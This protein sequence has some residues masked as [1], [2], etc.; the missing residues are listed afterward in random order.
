MGPEQIKL[1][2]DKEK[3]GLCLALSEL[4]CL[5]NDDASIH[6]SCSQGEIGRVMTLLE[7]SK[8]GNFRYARISRNIKLRFKPVTS[9]IKV[10]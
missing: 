2:W 1:A 7:E 5:F 4:A 8:L 6:T 3:R 10:T 9:R